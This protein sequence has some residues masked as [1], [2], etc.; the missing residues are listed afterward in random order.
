MGKGSLRWSEDQLNAHLQKRT[1]I[2]KQKT[3]KYRNQKV[4]YEGMQFDSQLELQ[5]WRELVMLAAA[6][7]ITDLRRQ[8]H[9]DLVVNGMLVTTYTADF[10][11]V[12]GGRKVTEEVKS[13]GTRRARD[14]PLR[15]KLMRAVHGIDIQVWGE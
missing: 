4:V 1:T 15:R 7:S 10:E 8:V 9:Y 14:W 3:S 2:A 6:K 12:E 13:A 5:R 11:Y